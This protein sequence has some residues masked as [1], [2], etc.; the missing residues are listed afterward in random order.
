MNIWLVQELP[1]LSPSQTPYISFGAPHLFCPQMWD[2][3]NFCS[4]TCYIFLLS[5]HLKG[6]SIPMLSTLTS[7]QVT[8]QTLTPALRSPLS[9]RAHLPFSPLSLVFW[10]CHKVNRKRL[11]SASIQHKSSIYQ[12]PA[13][14]QA[15]HSAQGMY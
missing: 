7:L 14:S 1:F 6:P 15:L 5:S 11:N 8:P 3:S 2:S 12:V 9:S 4:L 10:W 13:R